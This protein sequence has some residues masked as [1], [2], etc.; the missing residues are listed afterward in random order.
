MD[1]LR[2][3]AGNAPSKRQIEKEEEKL[4]AQR[5]S[6]AELKAGH[7]NLFEDLEQVHSSC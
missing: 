1:L 5:T 6:T 3:R 7:I 4:I 2:S